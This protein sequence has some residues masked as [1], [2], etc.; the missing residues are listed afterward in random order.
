MPRSTAS[1]PK[2][3]VGTILADTIRYI[4][5]VVIVGMALATVF[6][7]WTPNTQLSGLFAGFPN[8]ATPMAVVA[9]TVAAAP[10]TATSVV[11]ASLPRIGLVA[12]HKGKNGDP[13][14][15]CPDGLTE[16]SVNLDI[17]M[18]VKAGLEARQFQVDLLDEFD[19]RLEG[20]AALALVSIHNDSCAYINPQAT[21]FKVAGALDGGARDKSEKLTACLIDRYPRQT[22][23]PYHAHSVTPDMTNYH[24][25]YE[26][27]PTTPV[28][29]I[30][31][32]FLN[33]DREILTQQPYRVAQGVIDGILCFALNE[34]VAPTPTVGP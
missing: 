20:Y 34:P 25:F 21:G 11:S 28:A 30:E 24:S 31:T 2:T 23:M 19:P 26:V 6:T 10:P 5:L 27:K 14:A 13:G 8:L 33:L 17:A 18:R 22:G 9:T 4:G 1:T 3:P 32:G 16:A 7:A 29:I 15:V 12:G